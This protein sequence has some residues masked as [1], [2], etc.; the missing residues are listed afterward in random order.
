M[1]ADNRPIMRKLLFVLPVLAVL[2]AVAGC[3]G[4]GHPVLFQ[5]G[6][7][8][9]PVAAAE[10]SG[11]GAR[12][13]SRLPKVEMVTNKGTLIIEL[14][15]DEAPVSVGNFLMYVQDGF[16]NGTIFHRVEPGF[17]IQGGGFSPSMELKEPRPPIIN[18][19]GNGLRN[20][21]GTVAMARTSVINSATSQ[22]FIN[23]VDNFSFNG[24]GIMTGYAVFGRIYEGM[25]VVDA[26]ALS[27]TTSVGPF[28]NVPVEPVVIESVRLIE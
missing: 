3:R 8:A 10:G 28:D 2:A 20:M 7:T 24:D 23:L 4:K 26:I 22:F 27:D 18:E 25:D 6:Q 16:Y 21:R 17:V 19:A 11:S 13:E 1:R 5:P 15:E 14:F 12:P 9:W